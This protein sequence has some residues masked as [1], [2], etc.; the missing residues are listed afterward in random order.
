MELHHFR[1]LDP[2]PEPHKTEHLDPDHHKS[3]N[4]GALEAQNQALNGH[5]RLK[6]LKL[7]TLRVCIP[8]VADL[9][10]F[11]EDPDPDLDADPE[12]WLKG[13]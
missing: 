4:S 13:C 8:G 11:C 5:G 12:P 9:L 6:W 3:Q 1:K 10:K 7:E 2:D